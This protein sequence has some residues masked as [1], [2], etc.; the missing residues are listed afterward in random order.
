MNFIFCWTRNVIYWS[1]GLQLSCLDGSTAQG[2]DCGAADGPARP[3]V[4]A[5]IRPM[6]RRVRSLWQP[7]HIRIMS[8]M[9]GVLH[10]A[11]TIVLCV[12]NLQAALLKLLVSFVCCFCLRDPVAQHN[13]HEYVLLS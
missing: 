11:Y 2:H 8:C 6:E 7:A 9:S 4:M 10:A 3:V 1:V 13:V 5:A 12:C